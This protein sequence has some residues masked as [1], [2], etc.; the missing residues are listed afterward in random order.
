LKRAKDLYSGRLAIQLEASDDVAN[1]YA[2][3]AVME[4][5]LIAPEEFLQKI[6]AVTI[7]DIRRVARNIFVEKNLNLAVIGSQADAKQLQAALK[8]K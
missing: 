1:W 2:S 3:R 7:S 5:A 6:K 8:I 4:K